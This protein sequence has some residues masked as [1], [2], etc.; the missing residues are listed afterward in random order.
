MLFAVN[1]YNKPRKKQPVVIYK[2]T[3]LGKQ[4]VFINTLF[5]CLF[6]SHKNILFVGGENN[7]NYLPITNNFLSSRSPKKILKFIRCHNVGC[8]VF[9]DLPSSRYLYKILLKVGIIN[10]VF[11]KNVQDTVADFKIM[12]GGNAIEKYI[13]HITALQTYL[14]SKK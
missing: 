4:Y 10:V 6:S 1:L 9:Y 14:K 7:C 8:V 12:L 5:F 11:G 2:N 13:F 3:L